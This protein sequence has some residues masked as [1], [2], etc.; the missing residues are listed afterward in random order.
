MSSAR[1]ALFVNLY[2]ED[3]TGEDFLYILFWQEILHLS[4]AG[5]VP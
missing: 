5:N 2:N 3:N 4:S 1:N